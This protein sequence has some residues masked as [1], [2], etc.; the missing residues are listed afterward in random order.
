MFDAPHGAPLERIIF[1]VSGYKHLA[2]L[3]PET[4]AKA[5][6]YY[7]TTRILRSLALHDIHEVPGI[8]VK[9]QF[10]FVLFV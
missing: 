9:L 6:Q 2:A 10:Q 4:S 7:P 1:L 5:T 8:L 3:R